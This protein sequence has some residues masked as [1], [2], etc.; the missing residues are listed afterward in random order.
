MWERMGDD[1]HTTKKV[2]K[3]VDKRG[4]GQGWQPVLLLAAVM[5]VL[6]GVLAACGSTTSDS[7]ESTP[8]PGDPLVGKE[9]FF[10]TQQIAGA[11][12]CSS[13]HVVEA[14]EPAIVGPNLSG[15][16]VRA[17]TRVPGQ[18]AK[19]YL[20]MSV[21]DPYAYVLE[22]YQSGIM[23]RNYDELLTS[24]QINDLV[25]YMMTLN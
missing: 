8:G 21:V 19:D 23:V 24:Q 12:T 20:R 22:G 9:L 4:N 3:K 18:S 25:A 13:C 16:A 1:T 11:P 17:A 5:G 2:L 10:N 15:V 6:L 7:A 14:G